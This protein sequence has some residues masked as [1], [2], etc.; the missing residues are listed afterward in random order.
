MVS[1]I[2][3]RAACEC[4]KVTLTARGEPGAV[5]ACHCEACQRRTGSPLGVAAYFDLSDVEYKGETR[6]YARAAQEGRSLTQHFCTTCGGVVYF[7]ADKH[8]NGIGVPIGMFA[9]PKFPPPV[10]SVW[11][12]SRHE[13]LDVPG[14]SHHVR[15]RET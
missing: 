15:G 5:V 13:W 3:Y 6:A 2:V 8:A 14:V 4:G 12:Q 9:D 10:R 11:E 7:F 1:A